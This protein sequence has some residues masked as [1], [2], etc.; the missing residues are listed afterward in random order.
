MRIKD[1]APKS[2]FLVGNREQMRARLQRLMKWAQRQELRATM[3]WYAG[4][5]GDRR[6]S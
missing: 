1:I 2:L 3:D 5:Y 4:F 6:A